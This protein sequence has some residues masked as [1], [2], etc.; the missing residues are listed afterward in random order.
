MGLRLSLGN[1]NTSLNSL[2]VKDWLVGS[3]KRDVI[4]RKSVEKK[5]EFGSKGKEKKRPTL[6]ES[7]LLQKAVDVSDMSKLPQH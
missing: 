3:I 7:W 2:Q 5:K 1:A 4:K 6:E